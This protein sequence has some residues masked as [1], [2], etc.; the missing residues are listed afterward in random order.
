M[1]KNETIT[2]TSALANEPFLEAPLRA[3]L[4]MKFCVDFEHLPQPY[5]EVS[6]VSTI[7]TRTM[8]LLNRN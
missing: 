7:A 8:K 5:S 4:S 3:V 2:V 1:Y 6:E